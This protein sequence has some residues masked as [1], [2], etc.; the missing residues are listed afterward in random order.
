[1]LHLEN[2][3]QEVIG[4]GFILFIKLWWVLFIYLFLQNVTVIF[5]E[6]NAVFVYFNCVYLNS[7]WREGIDNYYKPGHL[8]DGTVHITLHC[9]MLTA[10]CT[11]LWLP[12]PLRDSF[13]RKE[14]VLKLRI[15]IRFNVLSFLFAGFCKKRKKWKC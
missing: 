4:Y 8:N 14:D 6:S 5:G 9:S 13:I 3:N 7:F 10:V 12:C 15:W 2:I 1:M 11:L